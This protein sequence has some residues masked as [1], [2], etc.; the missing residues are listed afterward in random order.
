MRLNGIWVRWDEVGVEIGSEWDV[1]WG[2]VRGEIR[3]G[4]HGI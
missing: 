1:G 3:M 4:L 2:W